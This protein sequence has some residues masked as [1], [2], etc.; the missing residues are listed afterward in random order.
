MIERQ[1]SVPCFLEKTPCREEEEEEN[2][3]NDGKDG[4]DGNDS[5]DGNEDSNHDIVKLVVI[6]M[7]H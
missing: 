7:M 3:D 6:M 1:T 5:N 4:N 2:K